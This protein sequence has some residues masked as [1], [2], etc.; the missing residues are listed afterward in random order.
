MTASWEEVKQREV[1]H[2]LR[3][4]LSSAVSA[5]RTSNHPLIRACPPREEDQRFQATDTAQRRLEMQRKAEERAKEESERLRRAAAEQRSQQVRPALAL[6]Q[7]EE[8]VVSGCRRAMLRGHSVPL[9]VVDTAF[10]FNTVP[11]THSAKPRFR[12]CRPSTWPPTS[13]CW[14]SCMRSRCS[15]RSRCAASSAQRWEGQTGRRLVGALRA[16]G[17][18]VKAGVRVSGRGRAG[19]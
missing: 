11:P 7:W 14:R 1:R 16:R 6:F 15:A 17:F 13:R 19:A 3:L 12:S 8:R 10:S 18:K 4:M 2:H 9:R 5:P